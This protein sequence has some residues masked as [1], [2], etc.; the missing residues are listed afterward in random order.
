MKN[1]VVIFVFLIMLAL[2]CSFMFMPADTM[3]VLEE[4]RNPA[5]MMPITA[6]NFSSGEFTSN[7]DSMLGDNIGFRSV[8]TST[9]NK[10][11]SL[12][13]INAGLG[14]IVTANADLGTDDSK[15]TMLLVKD[16]TVMEMFT[17]NIGSEQLYIKAINTFADYLDPK[18][19]MFSMLVP[20]QLEFCEPM[21]A[22]AEDSQEDTIHHIYSNLNKRITTVDVSPEL[23]AHKDEYIYFR[24]DHHWTMNGSYYGYRAFI[25]AHNNSDADTVLDPVDPH[26]FEEKYIPG[27]FVGYLAKQAE[28][29]EIENH[30]DSLTWYDVNQDGNFKIECRG[31]ND[32][33]KI[34][35]YEGT[36]FDTDK[37]GYA[38]FTAGDQPLMVI[39][40]NDMKGGKTI[41]VVKDSYANSFLP[42][43]ANNYHR[44]VVIDPRTYTEG[45][46]T[47]IDKYDPDE[48]LSLHY[49]FTTT[50]GDYCN[51][52]R[53]LA[54]PADDDTDTD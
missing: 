45:L 13:G 1:K 46:D 15:K 21:Y 22:N 26:D 42:W 18:V 49:T 28:T 50:F 33:G 37:I 5:T 35:K 10:I 3:S 17:H 43:L 39:T 4:N 51:M 19:K 8:L 53:D 41:F 44:V 32:D 7:F 16:N 20:T 31:L 40:N 24:T 23:R 30:P 2:S 14:K 12:R 27:G 9:S 48:F 25:N 47:L 38:L 29:P 52:M 36:F 34:D 11:K 6:E 54:V